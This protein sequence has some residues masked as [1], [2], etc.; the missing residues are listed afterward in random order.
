MLE[1]F[2][3]G[4]NWVLP[5]HSA[6]VMLSPWSRE[7]AAR[8]LLALG[9]VRLSEILGR[10][11]EFCRPPGDLVPRFCRAA[12]SRFAILCYHR[13]GQGGVPL[14]SGLPTVAFEAQ[15]RYLRRHYRV[16]SLD[17]ALCEMSESRSTAPAVAITFDDGYADLYTHAFPVL[18][19]YGIPAMIFLTVGAIESG[20]V[21]WYDRVFVAFQV[22]PGRELPLP[23]N[24]PCVIGLGTPGE[25]LH[26]AAKFISLMRELPTAE[27]RATCA[28]LE[29][30]VSL[31]RKSITNRMLTWEQIRDMQA[32]GV[33]FGAHTMTH[34]VV[35]RLTEEEL[36]WEVGES[37][38]ILE[39]RLQR[40]IL[41]FAFPFGKIDECGDAAVACLARFGFRSA[42]TTI[43]GLN[44][45]ATNPFA[46]RRV[47]FCE[48]GSLAIFAAR[49]ARLFLS[50]ERN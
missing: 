49:L 24:P 31:P 40:P 45:A 11:I 50:S 46:L 43:E 41:D 33:S 38:R 5:N 7:L 35:S 29:S 19:R 48:D 21:A 36:Y 14:Y 2:L 6:D 1:S 47:S 15:M 42:A 12:Q 30:I 17:Q 3:A 37:K 8:V 9:G 22:A 23:T 4:A 44:R 20:E 26:A 32:G 27:Q 10:H 13:V 18:Q 28:K 34:P 39:D 16:V 25:R